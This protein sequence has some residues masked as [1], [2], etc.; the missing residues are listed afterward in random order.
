MKEYLVKL[1]SE[2]LAPG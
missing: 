2:W 1:E